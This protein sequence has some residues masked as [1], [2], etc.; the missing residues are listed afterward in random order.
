[1]L[2]GG[3][4]NRFNFGDLRL[5][6]A[7]I[8]AC[9]ILLLVASVWSL[10]WILDKSEIERG[11]ARHDS[12]M[13]ALTGV[14]NRRHFNRRLQQEIERCERYRRYA[15]LILLDIDH[16]KELNDRFGHQ[17][18]D[19]VLKAIAQACAASIRATDVICRYGGEEF[20]II[21]PETTGQ[22]GMLLARKI[23]TLIAHLHFAFTPIRATVSLGVVQIGAASAEIAIGAADQALY[24]AKKLGRN[25]ECLWPDVEEPA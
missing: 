1:V 22:E 15:C 17:C 10:A 2:V 24:A 5:G 14:S 8:V 13:D 9:N 25:R 7:F 20:A 19:D 18:G 3:I 4:F 23:R 6:I 12:E 11:M 16:F 21:A